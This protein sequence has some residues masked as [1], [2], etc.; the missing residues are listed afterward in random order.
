[1]RRR[2]RR[3][4][5]LSPP[6]AT[7]ICNGI[8]DDCDTR[9]DEG[10]AYTPEAN[11]TR[12]SISDA[13]SGRGNVAW[14]PRNQTWGATYWDYSDGSAD[15][16]FQEL[17]PEGQ[18]I[19]SRTLLTL[20]PGD[21]FGSAILWNDDQQEYAIAWQDRRDGV[22]EIYFNR[23]TPDGQ[24]LG[25]DIRVTHIPHWSINPALLW[26]GQEYLLAWQDWRHQVEVPENFEIYVT[27]LDGE[28]FEIGDDIRLTFDPQN[29]EGPSLA[30]GDN[31]I[32]IAFVDGRTGSE[33]VW[34]MIIDYVGERIMPPTRLSTNHQDAFAPEISWVGDAFVVVWQE[35]TS[36]GD[37]DIVGSRILRPTA[38]SRRTNRDCWRRSVEPATSN[39]KQW[40]RASHRI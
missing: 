33:Q 35:E 23:L 17:S 24:K 7:E 21:A 34:A 29:S 20:D 5:R 28:G 26:N 27:F 39:P 2:L 13:P 18:P 3:Y 16:Y 15:V 1:M 8:D 12:L 10:A 19:G 38:I 4:Q 9:T 14:S 36:A 22:W 40:H 25:R 6:E 11:D 37:Y 31:E 32:A 30:L